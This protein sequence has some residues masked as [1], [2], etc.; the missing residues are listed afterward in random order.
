M[1]LREGLHGPALCGDP[2]SERA[3]A[4]KSR[5]REKGPELFT[6]TIHKDAHGLWADDGGNAFRLAIEGVDLIPGARRANNPDDLMNAPLDA[7]GVRW[8]VLD[9]GEDAPEYSNWCFGGVEFGSIDYD[10]A[11]HCR[12][13]YRLL[14]IAEEFEDRIRD[15]E[16][17]EGPAILGP[18]LI[19]GDA[20]ARLIEAL[21]HNRTEGDE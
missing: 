13:I 1:R 7:D 11:D 9:Q 8:D 10:D 20:A 6:I 15:D 17:F 18:R 3:D 21:G 19:E 5:R 4:G 16:E 2:L 14:R 12:V